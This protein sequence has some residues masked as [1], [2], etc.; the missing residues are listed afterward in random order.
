MTRAAKKDTF[1]STAYLF[2]H[3]SSQI[4]YLHI[5]QVTRHLLQQN[6]K[7]LEDTLARCEILSV[8]LALA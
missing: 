4:A 5:A 8:T 1:L 2:D 7:D 6:W 3:L